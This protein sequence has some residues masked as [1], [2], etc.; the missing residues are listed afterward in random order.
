MIS[1]RLRQLGLT[2]QSF[3]FK[4]S[5]DDI[6]HKLKQIINQFDVLLMSGGVSK[7][8]FDFIPEVLENLGI[9]KK[10]H[11]V[12]Q[13]PGKPFWFGKNDQI[14]VFAFPG[15]PVSTLACFQKYFIPWLGKSVGNIQP[16]L[17][18]ILEEDIIF[19]PDLT[20]FAQASIIQKE[21]GRFYAKVKH[22]NGSGD[23]VNP[24]KMDGFLELPAGK[25]VYRAGE[26]HDFMPFYPI[27][28]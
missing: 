12:L 4:D 18:V 14:T 10:F 26:V 8:K 16:S 21:D 1:S 25:E 6:T 3:H 7:G 20:Y 28:K 13:R 9:K 24:S 11:K 5:A 23:I 17:K 19:K 22:G 27:F 2:S 15:N